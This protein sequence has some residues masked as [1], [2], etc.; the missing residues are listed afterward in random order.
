MI[1]AFGVDHGEISKVVVR[2]TAV[3]RK[4]PKAGKL[5]GQAGKKPNAGPTTGFKAGQAAGKPVGAGFKAVG[6]AAGKG[7][8][9]MGLKTLGAKMQGSPLKAGVTTSFIGGVGGTAGYGAY[10]MMKKP[11]QPGQGV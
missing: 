10:G 7:A 9:A 11:K 6:S 8:S 1:S 5:F 4:L 3:L 2:P